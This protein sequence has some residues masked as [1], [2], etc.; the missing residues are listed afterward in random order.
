MV[1]SGVLQKEFDDAVMRPESEIDLVRSWLLISRLEYPELDEAFCRNELERLSNR[2]KKKVSGLSDLRRIAEMMAFVLCEQEGF[3]GNTKD[4]YAP[5]NSCLNRVLN[6]KTG[7][8]ITLGLVYMEVGRRAGLD[9]RGIAAPGHFIAGVYGA[10]GRCLMDPFYRGVVLDEN[11]F[12]RRV[13]VQHGGAGMF[14]PGLLDSAG[15]GAILVRL[16]TDLKGIYIHMGENV[17]ALQTV[18]WIIALNPDAAPEYRTRG[19]LY[20]TLGVNELAVRDWVKYVSLAPSAPDVKMV[21]LKIEELRRK[22]F[23]LH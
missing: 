6:R 11:E 8:P 21:R 10:G 22:G 20:E 16:I 3:S 13:A 23:V 19:C 12:R 7:I 15:P 4:Y 18:E 5:D 14:G 2:L 1:S 9:V 17:K